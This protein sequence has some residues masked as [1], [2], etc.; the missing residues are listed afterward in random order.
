[1]RGPRTQHTRS[2]TVELVAFFSMIV[3][4]TALLFPVVQSTQEDSGS[5]SVAHKVIG[6]YPVSHRGSAAQISVEL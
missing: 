1:M 5:R 4:L 6:V 3:L 2:T